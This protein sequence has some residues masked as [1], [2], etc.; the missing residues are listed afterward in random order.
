M[1]ASLSVCAVLVDALDEERAAWVRD[2]LERLAVA[3]ALGEAPEARIQLGLY[4]AQRSARN[5]EVQLR[6]VCRPAQF[7][8]R[9]W[10]HALQ[11]KLQA[12]PDAAELVETKKL[13]LSL[14]SLV[15]LMANDPPL[16]PSSQ[17]VRIVHVLAH[18]FHPCPQLHAAVEAAAQLGIQCHFTAIMPAPAVAPLSLGE[19]P[20]AAAL[21]A[22]AEPQ[23]TLLPWMAGGVIVQ[24]SPA[25]AAFMSDL[26]VHETSRVNVVAAEPLTAERTCGEWLHELLPAPVRS[27]SLRLPRQLAN[28]AGPQVGPQQ[29]PVG[30]AL[31]SAPSSRSH[32]LHL[33]L[34]SQLAPTHPQLSRRSLCPCHGLPVCCAGSAGAAVACRADASWLDPATTVADAEVVGVGAHHV[35]RLPLGTSPWGN[36]ALAG[37]RSVELVAERVVDGGSLGEGY[38]YGRPHLL[39]PCDI[40]LETD[41]EAADNQRAVCALCMVL[42]KSGG[43]LIASAYVDLDTGHLTL[44]KQWYSLVPTSTAG[45]PAGG[46]ATGTGVDSLAGAGSSAGGSSSWAASRTLPCFLVKHFACREQLLPL[47]ALPPADAPSREEL[48]AAEHA[49]VALPGCVLPQGNGGAARTDGKATAA[50]GG[51]V[52]PAIAPLAACT[53]AP[54]S[55]LDISSDLNQLVLAARGSARLAAPWAAAAAGTSTGTGAAATAGGAGAGA[56]AAGGAAAAAASGAGAAAAAAGGAGAGAATDAPIVGGAF[57]AQPPPRQGQ[58]Q[59]VGAPSLPARHTAQQPPAQPL[60]SAGAHARQ[61]ATST[62]PATISA[63]AP[64]AA[65]A[66]AAAALH[67]SPRSVHEADFAAAAA[68]GSHARKRLPR[69]TGSTAGQGQGRVPLAL[70]ASGTTSG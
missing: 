10:L 16:P 34:A 31:L 22:A 19:P 70:R 46:Q 68:G 1:S 18:S 64:A 3:V 24:L 4:V 67:V 63:A 13:A 12:H 58:G 57:A 69:G 5:K 45:Q 43:A 8:L 14:R 41:D 30:A 44:V 26:A 23:S 38:T 25:L 61:C 40:D 7:A 51:D 15:T 28:G 32:V 56:A 21:G 17:G 49:L 55:P 9:E 62:V 66:A 20:V 36:T 2:A 42:Q 65:P 52:V 39:F 54:F 35:L 60:I 37:S 27:C 53:L 6:I 11:G 59:P 47:P 29:Q 50:D 33:Q 48:E